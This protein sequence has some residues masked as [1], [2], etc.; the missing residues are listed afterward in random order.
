VEEPKIITHEDAWFAYIAELLEKI[1]DAIKKPEP[2]VINVSG[3]AILPEPPKSPETVTLGE[4]Q[5]PAKPA[6]EKNG[7]A[8]RGGKRG[9]NV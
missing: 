1:R 6:Q 3:T 7:S 5:N 8:K 2:K 4:N 9:K